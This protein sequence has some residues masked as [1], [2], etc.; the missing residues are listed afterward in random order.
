[1]EGKVNFA[2]ACLRILLGLSYVVK[3]DVISVMSSPVGASTERLL[4]VEDDPK[5]VRALARGLTGEG[6]AVDVAMTGAE[7]LA[8]ARETD[9]GV[10]VLDVMLPDVDG[11]AV[12]EQLRRADRRTPVLMLTA[13]GEV[14]SRIRGLDGGAD[15]YMVKPF[16]FGELFARLR[17]LVRRGAAEPDLVLEVGDLRIDRAARAVFRAQQR[18]ELTATEFRLLERLARAAGEVVSRGE[19]LDEVWDGEDG[20]SAN[21]VDVYVGYLRRKL[22]APF[23]RPI[24][25]TV[26]G[27]GYRLAND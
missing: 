21:V 7:A 18:V 24:I 3:F 20:V 8:H 26:R 19:L 5:L 12:C 23:G 25:H 17:A 4:V 1:V 2:A 15:D 22:E 6:Y 14:S 11:F 16:A 9:Y 10:I 13:R 27:V